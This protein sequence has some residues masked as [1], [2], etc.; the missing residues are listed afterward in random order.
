MPRPLFL[1]AWAFILGVAA[2]DTY[3]AWRYRAIFLNWRKECPGVLARPGWRPWRRFR[4][5]RWEW[6]SPRSWP[7]TAI[8]GAIVYSFPSR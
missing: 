2:Y 1:L 8:A 4:F 6:L 5:R 3:F 7:S